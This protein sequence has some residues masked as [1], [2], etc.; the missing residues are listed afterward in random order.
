M[1][2]EQQSAAFGCRGSSIRLS[3][4]R[5]L[6]LLDPKPE[7]IT[8]KNVAIP[9]SLVCRFGGCMPSGYHFYSVAEHSVECCRYAESLGLSARV[10][11][12]CLLHDAAEAFIGDVVKPLKILIDPLYGPIEK[13]IESAIASAFRV[14]FESTRDD[15]KRIDRTILIAERRFLFPPDSE[16]WTGEDEVERIDFNPAI[17][18]PPQAFRVFCDEFHRVAGLL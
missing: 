8:L 12:A 7:L 1:T 17:L 16:K 14:D 15:W 9:L 5:Y 13:R 2:I 3:D 18:A 10:Q 11:F 4:G 6:E